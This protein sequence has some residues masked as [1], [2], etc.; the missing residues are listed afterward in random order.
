MSAKHKFKA[1]DLVI[2]TED[3][4]FRGRVMG[5]VLRTH[6]PEGLFK[7][8]MVELFTCGSSRRSCELLAYED[9]IVRVIE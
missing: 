9:E 5:I 6:E 8:P 2:I 3:H 7:C 1:G 4:P